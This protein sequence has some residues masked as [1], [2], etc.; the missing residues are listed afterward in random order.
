MLPIQGSPVNEYII[1]LFFQIHFF[2]I[3][4]R[5]QSIYRNEIHIS[6][7]YVG[8]RYYLD[9]WIRGLNQDK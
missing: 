2:K 5:K 9:I 7:L 3:I 8:V 6:I 1:Y 4:Y